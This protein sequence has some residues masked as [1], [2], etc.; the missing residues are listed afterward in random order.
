MGL[1]WEE[2]IRKAVEKDGHIHILG[3]EEEEQLVL[4]QLA[5]YTTFILPFLELTCTS[6]YLN[7]KQATH[8]GQPALALSKTLLD[9]MLA[10]SQEFAFCRHSQWAKTKRYFNTPNE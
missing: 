1:R 3:N 6:G 4:A 9:D 7:T 8:E 2:E 10:G 5:N